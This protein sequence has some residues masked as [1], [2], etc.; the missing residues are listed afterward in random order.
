MSC[1]IQWGVLTRSLVIKDAP[2]GNPKELSKGV[3]RATQRLRFD[4]GVMR[5]EE[6]EGKG[7]QM[8]PEGG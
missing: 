4:P 5:R 2:Q 7:R 1:L 3:Q 8:Q 6:A